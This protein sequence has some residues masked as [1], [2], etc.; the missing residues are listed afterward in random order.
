[1]QADLNYNYCINRKSCFTPT[2]HEEALF[3]ITDSNVMKCDLLHVQ[4]PH[5]KI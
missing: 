2:L 3:Q 4:G 1:M 5:Y